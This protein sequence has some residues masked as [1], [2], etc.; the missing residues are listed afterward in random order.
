MLTAVSSLKS[1]L[2]N[3]KQDKETQVYN[4]TFISTADVML[5]FPVH[6]RTMGTNEPYC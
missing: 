4:S 5:G 2:H 1:L 6:F 3:S